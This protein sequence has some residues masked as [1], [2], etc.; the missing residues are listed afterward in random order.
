VTGLLAERVGVAT[1]VGALV[2]AALVTGAFAAGAFVVDVLAAGAFGVPLLLD[3]V[4]VAGRSV[5][6]IGTTRKGGALD[7][8]SAAAPAI[9]TRPAMP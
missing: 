7:W 6:P 1:V 8:A 4:F 3:G 9:A 2:A 5:S